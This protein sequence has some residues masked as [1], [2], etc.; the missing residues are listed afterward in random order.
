[1]TDLVAEDLFFEIMDF[2]TARAYLPEGGALL[3]GAVHIEL[4]AVRHL[5]YDALS[6]A[7][8]RGA[9]MWEVDGGQF[10]SSM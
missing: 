5:Q 4:V 9:G 2:F 1:M 6:V 3:L 8:V 10:A 7:R